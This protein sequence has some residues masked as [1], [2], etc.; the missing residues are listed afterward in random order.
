MTWHVRRPRRSIS[1]HRHVC[2]VEVR[3]GADPGEE[4]RLTRRSLPRHARTWVPR[5]PHNADPSMLLACGSWTG[6]VERF[7]SRVS[8]VTRERL[9]SQART[10]APRLDIDTAGASR[11]RCLNTVGPKKARPSVTSR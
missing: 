1:N 3:V 9:P 2:D 8:T 10:G 11:L 4:Q 6:A 5:C 7:P